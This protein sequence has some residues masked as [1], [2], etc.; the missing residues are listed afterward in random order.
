[1][2]DRHERHAQ[3]LGGIVHLALHLERHAARAFVQDG[4][5]GRVVEEARHGDALLQADGEDVAPF[6]LG[7]PA[8][9]PL[10]D[11][12]D[13]D[14]FEPAQEVRVGGV[15][16]AHLAQAVGVDDL[17]A[18]GAA[19]EVGALRDVEDAAVGGFVDCAAVDGPEAAE[20]TEET[21]FAAAVG[22]DYEEVVAGADREGEGFDEDVA[23]WR[24]DGDGD[25]FDVVAFDGGAARR[26]DG[27]VFGCP[28]RG[29]ELFLET[30]GLYVVHHVEKRCYS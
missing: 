28:C 5:F 15:L 24:D 7:V 17:L 30:T 18:E 21:A 2:T 1:M 13:V 23:V 9:R 20:D 22:A 25:E 6:V 26:E 16:G 29:Y 3:R 11:V 14:G 10:D 27:C 19:A 4:V 12:R 8:A